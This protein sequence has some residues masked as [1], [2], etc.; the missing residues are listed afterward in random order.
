MK[1]HTHILLSILLFCL[2]VG[3]CSASDIL[4]AQPFTAFYLESTLGNRSLAD[5][6]TVATAASQ[7]LQPRKSPNEAF[8]YSLV[9]PGMGQ[10]YT[11]AK[12]GYIYTAAEVGFLATFFL[13]RNSASNI[14]DDYRD[15]V[16]EHV[17]FIGP[18]SFEDWDPIEDFEHATQYETW[19]HDY[20]TEATQKRTGKWYWKDLDPDLKNE[21][22][23]DLEKRGITSSYRQEAFDLREQANDTFE[24]AKFFLGLAILNHAISAVEARI[25]TKRFNSRLENTL[26][27][28][29]TRAFDIDVQADRFT[30]A[31]TGT[32]VLRKRF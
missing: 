26:T 20:D 8:L 9:I 14:R 4:Q 31:L 30:G 6:S 16:R 11:G 23:R 3:V 18:G 10:L 27:Q 15:V 13:L 12:H 28:P 7:A 24:R 21:R 25:T 29:Q 1:F 17:V 2:S 5:Q 32:L 19:N 22:H